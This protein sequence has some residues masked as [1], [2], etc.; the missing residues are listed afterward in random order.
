M[1]ADTLDGESLTSSTR[2]QASL[3]FHPLDSTS[4]PGSPALGSTKK[5]PVPGTGRSWGGK[6]KERPPGGIVGGTWGY[7]F[8]IMTYVINLVTQGPIW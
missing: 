4:E 2:H 6:R 8:S 1:I 7:P 5:N 3:D